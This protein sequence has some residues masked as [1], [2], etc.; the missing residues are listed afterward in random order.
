MS[1]ARELLTALVIAL[2]R[3]EAEWMTTYTGYKWVAEAKK[4]ARA[5]L[6]QPAPPVGALDVEALVA[7]L[8]ALGFQSLETDRGRFIFTEHAAAAIAAAHGAQP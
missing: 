3:Y 6:A 5:F 1:D 4:Q 7:A 2:N 8:D